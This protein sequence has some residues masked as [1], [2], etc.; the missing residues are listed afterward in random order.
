MF[1]DLDILA[2]THV[3]YNGTVC[4]VY[5]QDYTTMAVFFLLFSVFF[6]IWAFGK[7]ETITVHITIPI[8]GTVTTDTQPCSQR[9]RTGLGNPTNQ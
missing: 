8:R 1:L 2:A 7:N 6:F 5:I 4:S 9:P 3:L